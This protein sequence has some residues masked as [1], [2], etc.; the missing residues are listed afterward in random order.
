MTGLKFQHDETI[1]FDK[2]GIME[3]ISDGDETDEYT[4]YSDESDNEHPYEIPIDSIVEQEVSEEYE[5]E[6]RSEISNRLSLKTPGTFVPRNAREL[7]SDEEMYMEFYG[8]L[9]KESTQANQ[10]F[11]IGVI[12]AWWHVCKKHKSE[13]DLMK[14]RKEV[15]AWNAKR[16]GKYAISRL[17]PIVDFDVEYTQMITEEKK[18][19]MRKQ[20]EEEKKTVE[21]AKKYAKELESIMRIKRRKAWKER[22]TAKKGCNKNSTWHKKR[23]Q[24][25]FVLA[26][27]NVKKSIEGHGRRSVKTWEAVNKTVNVSDE[28]SIVYVEHNTDV[29]DDTATSDIY[30]LMSATIEAAGRLEQKEKE[31]S[32]ARELEKEEE[33]DEAYFVSR[34][35]GQKKKSTQKKSVNSG[36]SATRKFEPIDVKCTS[37]IA[38]AKARRRAVDIKFNAREQG[39]MDSMDPESIKNALKCTILCNSIKEQKKCHHKKCRFAH[40]LDELRRATCRFGEGCQFILR[41]EDGIYTNKSYP[42]KTASKPTRVCHF[43]HPGEIDIQF[44]NRLGLPYTQTLPVPTTATTTTPVPTT[45]TTPVPTTATTTTPYWTPT[46]TSRVT[47][48]WA[49]IVLKSLT[50]YVEIKEESVEEKPETEQVQESDAKPVRVSRWG[51][52]R[53]QESEAKPVRVSRWD[54]DDHTI[55]KA[56]E[57]A[58]RINK[59]LQEKSNISPTVFKVNKENAATALRSAMRNGFTNIKITY[60]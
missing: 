57:C 30:E 34:M 4:M 17:E 55:S 16:G 19:H 41:D 12:E 26:A 37:I 45:A 14:R 49:L 38:T 13:L 52:K 15:L 47:P 48:S 53:V 33:D 21:D 8:I 60:F 46:K 2:H 58:K 32:V 29:Q 28:P 9:D 1:M 59:Q 44:C 31:E 18:E 39:F 40:S 6:E 22:N 5:N 7:P 11:A 35:G 43:Q 56:S 23:G 20:A 27:K 54:V 24:N 36:K 10:R 51:A 25:G 50:S 3:Y 42:H